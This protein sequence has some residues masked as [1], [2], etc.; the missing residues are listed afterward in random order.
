MQK[1]CDDGD[2]GDDSDD[3]DDNE[4]DSNDAVYSKILIRK[5]NRTN[6]A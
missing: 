5:S 3:G 1:L 4:M 2:D 6:M